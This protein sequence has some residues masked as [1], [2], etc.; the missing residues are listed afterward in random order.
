MSR[1]IIAGIVSFLLAF[2]LALPGAG[3]QQDAGQQSGTQAANGDRKVI[4]QLDSQ[5]L[6]S[7][8][9]DLK[10]K[11]GLQDKALSRP[12]ASRQTSDNNGLTI[13]KQDTVTQ[14]IGTQAPPQSSDSDTEPQSSEP[15]NFV[16][17]SDSQALISVIVEL[18]EEP[19]KVFEAQRS[20]LRSKLSVQSQESII[21]SEQRT[22]KAQALNKLDVEFNREYSGIFNG[23]SL[24][25]PANKVDELLLLP[26][27][28]AI[29]PNNTVYATADDGDAAAAAAM[30]SSTQFIGSDSFWEDGEK[31]EGIKVGVIDTGIAKDHPDLE[32]VIPSGDWGYDFVN[33]DNEPYE[34][35]KEDYEQAK[36]EDPNLPETEDGRPYWTSHGTHVSGVIAGQNV[37]ADGK[38]GV[39][40]IAPEA[41]LHAYKVLGPYGSGTSEDVLA[42]IEKAVE[43]GMDVINLSLGSDFNNEKTAESIALNN[44]ALAGVIPV[45]SAGNS[46]PDTATLG[47]PGTS[48]MA[49]SVA[50]SKS[51]QETPIV[52][53]NPMEDGSFFMEP[54]AG[55]PGLDSLSG[56]YPLVDA[57]LGKAADFKGKNLKGKIAL[58]KR[59]EFNF[60]EKA[61]NAQK[62]GAAAVLIYNNLPEALETGTVEGGGITIPVY[63]LSGVDGDKIK[64]A[65]SSHALTAEL[66]QVI[67]QDI[68]ASFSS[69]GPAK[70]SYTMKPDISAPGMNIV[71]SVPEYEG[72]YESESGTS[73]AAPHI[74]GAAALIRQKYPELTP[75]EIKSLIM[76]NAVSMNDRSG[77]RYSYMDQG[78]G[79]IDLNQVMDAKAIAMVQQT[80][81]AVENQVSAAYHTGSLSLGYV[82]KGTSAQRTV[83]IKDLSGSASTYTISSSWYGEAAGAADITLSQSLVEVAPGGDASFT[84][85]VNMSGSAAADQLYEGKLMLTD[86]SSGDVI[87]LPITVYAGEA[88]QVNT[89]SGLQA[90][91]P[92][93][94]PN[95]DGVYDTSDIL[96]NIN[97]YTGYFSLDVFSSSMDWLGTLEEEAEAYPGQYGIEG[98]DGVLDGQ[99][100]PDGVYYLIPFAGD[101]YEDA[102]PLEDEA[103][104]FVIDTEAPESQ[105]DDPEIE[106]DKANMAGTISGQI[107][108]DMLIDELTGEGGLAV[109]DVV[110]AAALYEANGEFVQADG[111]VDD[112]GHFTI[113]VPLALGENNIEIYVYD[114]AGNGN[115]NPAHVVSYTFTGVAPAASPSTVEPNAGFDVAVN[116]AVTDAVY[117]AKFDLLYSKQLGEAA[118]T[119]SPELTEQQAA[120]NP[121]V[122]LTVSEAVYDNGDDLNRHEFFESLNEAD[123]YTGSGSLAAFHFDGAPG[124]QYTFELSS[125]ILMDK[126]GNPIAVDVVP[127]AQVTVQEQPELKVQPESVSVKKGKSRQLQVVYKDADGTEISVTNEADYS[128]SDSRIASVKEGLVTGQA[129]GQT[130]VQVSYEGLTVS[131]P[132]TVTTQPSSPSTGGS[133]TSA[134]APA[135]APA[136]PA[137]GSVKKALEAGKPA[138]L[139]L[140]NGM[141]VTLPAGGTLPDNAAFAQIK[142]STAAEAKQ[143]MEGLKLDNSYTPLGDYY[144]FS[145]LDKNSSA[146]SGTA[147]NPPAAVSIPLEALQAGGINGETIN[148]YEISPQG[149]LILHAG[150]LENG[151]VTAEL[152]SAGRYMFM[153]KHASFADVTNLNYPWAANAIEVLASKEI[154]TG[155]GAGSFSPGKEVTRAEFV[156]LLVRALGLTTSTST[157]TTTGTGS[158]SQATFTDV[159]AGSWYQDAVKAAAAQGWISG[160]AD[161][162]FAPDQTITRSEMAVILARALQASGQ[163]LQTGAQTSGYADQAEIQAWAKDAIAQITGLGIMQGSPDNHFNGDQAATRAETAV[164]IYRIFNDYAN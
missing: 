101:S 112:E 24:T 139:E 60:S 130:A 85:T 72:W 23:Y 40:G 152:S 103:G 53:I 129:V 159:P 71:S 18:Q 28:K 64:A 19:V 70:Q 57:G 98:W 69:R 3:A 59:G 99:K 30:E 6:S 114:L 127:A 50:A 163:P 154:I 77:S 126:D 86:S 25:L 5:V 137:D 73:M 109:S 136:Q 92:A 156:T 20:K 122:P 8:A 26:G 17:S 141:T 56:A 131:V 7:G 22:F 145:I 134:P 84:A 75:D 46:G 1:R 97:K 119:P 95:D 27:V 4:S 54:F 117:S 133:S 42:G 76:N 79:R 36:K 31:G 121:E 13:E 48:E 149:Q 135:P 91:P 158:S 34:T 93:F 132:V 52:R 115:I 124:G 83:E 29:Y 16:A 10:D 111:K 12:T 38:P 100:L 15:Q 90:S 143:L 142:P 147:L 157:S 62:A 14:E 155:T 35:T 140:E 146:I 161:Q 151:E 116:F 66:S 118:V 87:A 51:P 160:Y 37:G 96:F 144:E 106:V 45:V 107:T 78:A 63:A 61:A 55:S 88:P 68:L 11:A 108:Q 67:E 9:L 113:S 80:T 110:G 148:L 120:F 128:V 33:D 74:A 58:I 47:E 89:V 104:L 39:E 153:A 164:V 41:E 43:D 105:L 82:A 102:A 21:D 32:A 2:T 123:G 125:V 81:D 65:L 138:A 162:T 150:H 94:S 49:I 44:A